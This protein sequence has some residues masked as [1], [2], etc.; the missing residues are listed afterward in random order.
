MPVICP[1]SRAH[2]P[3]QLTTC[4]ALITPFGVVTSHEPSGR[5]VVAVAGERVGDTDYEWPIF[6]DGAA[7][8]DDGAGGWIHTVN[9]EV[10]VPGAAG[11]SAVHFDA[12][13]FMM[14][15]LVLLEI[16]CRR[17]TRSPGQPDFSKKA[18]APAASRK[19]Q[20]AKM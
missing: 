16:A 6:P 14:C 3:P 1:T 12:C 7:I 9:S 18:S 4:S 11:V 15:Y 10:F 20:L 2:S 5:W 13:V 17:A 19:R 8:F